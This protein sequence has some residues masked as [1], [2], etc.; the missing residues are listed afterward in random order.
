MTTDMIPPSDTKQ[1]QLTA[2][3]LGAERKKSW[4]LLISLLSRGSLFGGARLVIGPPIFGYGP[5][6]QAIAVVSHSCQQ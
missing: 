1:Q 6:K 2:L 5:Y 3:Y 4:W